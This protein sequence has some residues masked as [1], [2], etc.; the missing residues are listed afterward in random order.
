MFVAIRVLSSLSSIVPPTPFPPTPSSRHLI[1]SHESSCESKEDA[2]IMLLAL[3]VNKRNIFMCG[4][5]HSFK[6]ASN[7]FSCMWRW[8]PLN[9]QCDVVPLL[10]LECEKKCAVTPQKDANILY[11]DH[12]SLWLYTSSI[13]L[14]S[15]IHFAEKIMKIQGNPP[16][17]VAYL[18]V[19]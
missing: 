8:K 18:L 19:L 3:S 14:P 11:F 10:V 2:L 6:Q 5:P 7:S 4:M 1:S 9:S 15:S 12:M 17:L 13:S 16:M